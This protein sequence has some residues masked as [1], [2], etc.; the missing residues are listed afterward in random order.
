MSAA[1]AGQIAFSEAYAGQFALS[2]AYAGQFA[3][4][5]AYDG[6]FRPPIKQLMLARLSSILILGQQEMI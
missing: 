6:E 2:A 1:S 5:A 4:S 3:N